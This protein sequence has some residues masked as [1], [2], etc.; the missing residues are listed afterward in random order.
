MVTRE[1][2]IHMEYQ[3]ELI[4]TLQMNIFAIIL[5]VAT[6]SVFF[7]LSFILNDPH[8]MQR[9]GAFLAAASAAFAIFELF[10]DEK[11]SVGESKKKNVAKKPKATDPRPVKRIAAR[12]RNVRIRQDLSRLSTE[13]K[14]FIITASCMAIVGEIF[15]GFGDLIFK[16]L[17]K[18]I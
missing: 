10:I 6:I 18:L 2:S 4:E 3:L 12:I 11:I 16:L 17:L 1:S 9:G 15:H 5:S 7:Y 14:K 13:K 8:W